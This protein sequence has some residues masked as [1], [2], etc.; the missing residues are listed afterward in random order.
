[1]KSRALIA[2]LLAAA[3]LPSG[4]NTLYKSVDANGTVMF[5]DVPPPAG[6]RILE[7]RAVMGSPAEVPPAGAPYSHAPNSAGT[8]SIEQVYG[9]MDSDAA[10][11]EANARVDQAERALAMARNG[12]ASRFEGLRLASTRSTS[13]DSE[14][15]EF[16]KRDLR[17]ARRALI[18]LIKERQVAAREPG[19]PRIVASNASGSLLGAVR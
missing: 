12:T 19:A 14:R 16:Y 13:A 5:S 11:A 17:L 2:L 8:A 15:I 9:L 6:A 18:D 1:M 7:E 4:A 3:A 10:L